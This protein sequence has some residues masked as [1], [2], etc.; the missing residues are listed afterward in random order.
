MV[1]LSVVLFFFSFYVFVVYFSAIYKM[2]FRILI[3][4]FGLSHT[5]T[6]YEVEDLVSWVIRSLLFCLHVVPFD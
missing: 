6:Y 4:L 2:I 5:T 3:L 1:D